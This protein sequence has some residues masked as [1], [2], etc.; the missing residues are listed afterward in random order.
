VTPVFGNNPAFQIVDVHRNGTVTGYTAWHLPNVTLPWSREY[1]FNDA[2]R[3]PRYDTATLTRLAASIG[4]DTTT[5]EQY[6]TYT[7][8]GNAKSTAGAL[9]KWQ[10]Y[11]CGLQAMNG[12]AFEA[13]YCSKPR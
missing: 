7:S 11:W 3:K 12:N 13:C 10:G 9:A 4:D 6:F 5:R 2:Y 8:S 1:S